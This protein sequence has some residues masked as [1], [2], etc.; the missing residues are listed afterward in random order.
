MDLGTSLDGYQY[1]ISVDVT[2]T[3]RGGGDILNPQSAVGLLV[4][5]DANQS[6][7]RAAKHDQAAA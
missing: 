3:G 5:V 7:S 2:L 6:S 1:S 4:H